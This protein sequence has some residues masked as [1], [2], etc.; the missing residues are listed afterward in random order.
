MSVELNHTINPAR[1][2][3]ASAKFLADSLNLE[4]GP[5][6]GHFAPIRTANGVTLDFADSEDFPPQHY[7]FLVSVAEFDA[8][9]AR[10]RAGGDRQ[11]PAFAEMA[12]IEQQHGDCREE[13]LLG[14]R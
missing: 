3:W 4:T 10:I 12:D 7:T 14:G 9:L 8:A 2:R 13:G 6:W 11:V 1:D 5:K